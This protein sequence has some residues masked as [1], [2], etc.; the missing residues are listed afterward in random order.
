MVV[1]RG[2]G[3]G[4]TNWYRIQKGRVGQRHALASEIV[5][6]M[7]DKLESA[8]TRIGSGNQWRVSATVG[9]GRR[10]GQQ[11][12]FACGVD[13]EQLDFDVLRGPAAG[14]IE[15]VRGQ[16]SQGAL[17][18]SATAHHSARAKEKERL[19]SVGPMRMAAA[20]HSLIANPAVA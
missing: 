1:R 14:D 13:L 2:I 8:C 7:E 16:S 18:A 20:P 17:L 4:E 12:A 3:D 15:N 9:V 10:R 5:A 19:G 6:G 11:F